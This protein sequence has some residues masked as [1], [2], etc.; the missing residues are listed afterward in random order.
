MIAQILLLKLR[1]AKKLG[2]EKEE[3]SQDVH[4]TTKPISKPKKPYSLVRKAKYI[5]RKLEIKDILTNISNPPGTV[6]PS[7]IPPIQN[8]NPAN[9]M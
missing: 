8:V 5:R 4:Q 6:K 7:P 2:E 3:V 9:A 1:R